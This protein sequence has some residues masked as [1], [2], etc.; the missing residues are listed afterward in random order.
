ME[1]LRRCLGCL[2]AKVIIRVGY[3][4]SWRH[5]VVGNL[6]R[7]EVTRRVPQLLSTRETAE[8]ELSEGTPSSRLSFLGLYSSMINRQFDS[9]DFEIPRD[10]MILR[11]SAPILASRRMIDKTLYLLRAQNPEQSM[12]NF[13]FRCFVTIVQRKIRCSPLYLYEYTDNSIA[14]TLN[15]QRL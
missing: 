14:H 1:G 9:I 4:S 8:L 12:V 6:D 13:L 3:R 7:S 15:R 10:F 5:S 2:L 11:S